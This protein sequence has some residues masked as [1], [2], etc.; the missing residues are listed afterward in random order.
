MVTNESKNTGNVKI[1]PLPVNT[2]TLQDLSDEA[3]ESIA[4]GQGT[5]TVQN[6][7]PAVCGAARPL[8]T[9]D[10]AVNVPSAACI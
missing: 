3:Q 4:G 2:E 8:A 1:D 6:S 5:H 9:V 7:K 10:R